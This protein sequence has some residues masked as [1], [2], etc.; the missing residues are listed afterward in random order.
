MLQLVLLELFSVLKSPPSPQK[1][2]T[3]LIKVV[4]SEELCNI[5]LDEGRQGTTITL[6]SGEYLYLPELYVAVLPCL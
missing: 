1:V 5:P 2:P 3:A 4:H 6:H